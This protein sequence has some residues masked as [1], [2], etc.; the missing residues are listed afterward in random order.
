MFKKMIRH[1][2]VSAAFLGS[3]LLVAGGSMWAWVA[4]QGIAGSPLILHFDDIEG[5]T[6]VGGP[7]GFLFMGIL[8]MVVVLFNFAIALELEE[9][10]R[11]LGKI[12]AGMTFIFAVLLFVSFAAIIN[13]N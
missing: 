6:A 2:A 9:R 11:F 13:V 5:I 3:L 12:T 1:K 4:L 10:D 7:G 8:G